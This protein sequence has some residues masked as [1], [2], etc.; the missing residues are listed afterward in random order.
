MKKT[1]IFSILCFTLHSSIFSQFT[2]TF[3]GG[4]S[5][6]YLNNN[7]TIGNHLVFNHA[8]AGVINWGGGGGGDLYFRR[9]NTQGTYMTGFNNLMII[10]ADGRVGMNG[11]TSPVSS[12]QIKGDI[13]MGNTVNGGK[14]L[15]HTQD[16]MNGDFFIVPD[17]SS[18]VS[19]WGKSV[20]LERSTGNFFVGDKNNALKVV[21]GSAGGVTMG[22][23]TGYIG[24]NANRNVS[25]NNWNFKSDGANSGAAMMWADV[26]GKLRISSFQTSGNVDVTQTDAAVVDHRSLTIGWVNSFNAGLGGPQITIGKGLSG[27]PHVNDYTLAVPGKIVAKEVVVTITNWADFVFEDDYVLTPLKEVETYVKEN[28]HLPNVPSEEELKT[29]GSD[30]ATMD[31][32]LI[33]KIEEMQLYI[34]DLQKQIDEL[35]TQNSNTK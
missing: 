30:V 16:W 2:G 6:Q 32:I 35:K 33:R 5:Q 17:N 31:A 28:K 13:T 9:L 21:M 19:D 7:V 1:I 29:T 20:R 15:L 23:G 25:A 18:G 3:P 24:F 10:K 4:S 8:T 34:I 11:I 12:L 27:G 26:D 22:Y 14:W